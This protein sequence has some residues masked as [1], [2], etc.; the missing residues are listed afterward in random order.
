VQVGFAPP[1][2]KD[3]LA[4]IAKGVFQQAN[5]GPAQTAP[6]GLLA[7]KTHARVTR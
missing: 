2:I 6:P 3:F 5:A 4:G 1:E 7:G